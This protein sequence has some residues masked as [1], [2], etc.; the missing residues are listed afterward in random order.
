MLVPEELWHAVGPDGLRSSD[1][2]SDALWSAFEASGAATAAECLTLRRLFER[3]EELGLKDRSPS[4][5]HDAVPSSTRIMISNIRERRFS[6][7]HY[8][9]M[10]EKRIPVETPAPPPIK[11]QLATEADMAHARLERLSLGNVADVADADDDDDE[12][13]GLGTL[14]TELLLDVLRRLDV[15]SLCRV[16]ATFRVGR[17]SVGAPELWRPVLAAFFDGELPAHLAHSAATH[18]DPRAVLI[19]QVCHGG[20]VPWV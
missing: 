7:T 8:I 18:A 4:S 13:A 1:P 6:A 3:A 17:A 5:N 14:P 11:P 12:V 10:W 16:G 20:G 19:H 15:L 9:A 2:A